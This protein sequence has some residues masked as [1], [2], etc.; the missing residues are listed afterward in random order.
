MTAL[1]AYENSVILAATGKAGMEQGPTEKFWTWRRILLAVGYGLVFLDGLW[2]LIEADPNG[3]I[4]M[5]AAIAGFLFLHRT[6]VGIV[7]WV[8][9]AASG[10]VALISG[11]DTGYYGI[12]ASLVFGAL[13]LP[14]RKRQPAQ[15]PAPYYYLQQSPF[16][17][18]PPPP[19]VVPIPATESLAAARLESSRTQRPMIRTI[20][21]L[22]IS[23][24]AGDV[25]SVVMGKPVIGFLWLYLFARSLRKPGDRL[26][27]S[28]LMDEVAHGVADPRGRLRGYFRDL[29]RLPEPLGSMVKVED[30]LVGFDLN[31]FAADVVELRDMAEKVRLANGSIHDADLRAAQDLLTEI[32]DGEF[33]P[34]FEDMEKRVTK[35]RGDAGRIVAAVR[36]QVDKARADLADIVANVLLD[37]GQ[38]ASAVSILE[39]IVVRSEDRDDIARTLINALRESGQHNRAAEIRRR[40][41]VGQEI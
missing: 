39:P 8:Y 16:I 34:G 37:R 32:R 13:A 11:D 21:F 12:F 33:L 14:W 4:L 29:A 38:A 28:S 36:V 15:R 17:A 7:V 1:R 40:F 10:I 9:V 6:W 31:G 24:D 25:T 41:A 18:P 26:T 20:G 2:I 5:L 19:P 30:E 23:T 27:R 22:R 35:G 3:L